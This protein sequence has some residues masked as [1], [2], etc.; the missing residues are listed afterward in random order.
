MQ[1]RTQGV[2]GVQKGV[3]L[4]FPWSLIW[5]LVHGHFALASQTM[6]SSLWCSLPLS[7]INPEGLTLTL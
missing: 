6:Q 7:E 4:T 3:F 5:S 1:P 2:M